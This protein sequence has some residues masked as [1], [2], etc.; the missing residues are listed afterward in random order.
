[1]PALESRREALEG[2]RAMIEVILLPE[3]WVDTMDGHYVMIDGQREYV[4]NEF[5]VSVLAQWVR[6]LA[7]D[8]VP[9]LDVFDKNGHVVGEISASG[10]TPMPYDHDWD[11]VW[12]EMRDN[13]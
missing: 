2:E 3:D 8:D 11:A 7:C 4:E 5:E 10:F 13:A 12:K 9:S 6:R 1:M